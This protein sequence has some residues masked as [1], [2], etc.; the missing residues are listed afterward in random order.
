MEPTQPTPPPQQPQQPQPPKG[1]PQQGGWPAPAPG[2]YTSPGMPY[3]AGL[4]GGPPGT[5]P[6]GQPRRTTNGLAIGSLVSG[7]VC[8]LPPL[9]LILGLVALPQIKKRGQE[10]KG[11]AVTGIV[12]SVVSCLLVVVGFATGGVR[13]AWDGFKEGVDEAAH[14]KSPMDLRTG[15]CF[16]DRSAE[17]AEYTTGVTVVDCAKPHEGE[18]TGD[19]KLTGFEA[20]PGEDAIDKIA[21]KRCETVNGAY[22]LDT[23]AVPLDAWTYYYLPSKQS[24]RLGDRTVTCAYFGDKKKLTGSLR[25]DATTLDADQVHFLKTLNPI[26]TV[27]YTEP[28]ADPDEDLAANKK[29]AGKMLAAIDGARTGLRGHVWPGGARAQ[30]DA[31]G[32]QLAE[33]SEDWGRLAS[34]ADSETYWVAYDAAWDSLPDDLG[35][36]VRTALR[37]TAEPPAD[38]G[39]DTSV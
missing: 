36:K 28:E 10:G 5:G 32:Q 8:C 38:P 13:T 37:L 6:Y 25:A 35:V 39:T 29:W 1:G 12:L 19:F 30:A 2:P 20:W 4:Y 34:A 14:S 18:V 17:K 15:Q 23:W 24:W 21:E 31:L 3:A 11:L 33:A 22:A 7:I 16:D 9:G 26:E 27:S